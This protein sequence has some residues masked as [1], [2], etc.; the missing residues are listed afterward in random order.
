M[1][2]LLTMS[3]REIKRLKILEQVN[4]DKLSIKEAITSLSVCERQFYR[5][6]KRYREEG[7]KGLVHKSRGKPSN[8]GYPLELKEKVINLYRKTYKDFGPTLFTEKLEELHKIEID[9]ET[10]RRWLRSK[11]EI[12]STRR[13]RGHRKKRERKKSIGEMLQFDGS[14]HDW[15]EGRAPVCCLLHA[16][17]DASSRVFLRF[18]KSENTEEV[19]KTMREY[20]IENGIPHSIYTDRYGVYYAEKEKTDFQKAMSKLGVRCIYANSPQAKGRVERGNRTLQ[21]RLVKEMRLRGISSIDEANKFLRESFIADYNKKF[22]IQ[23]TIP[24][25]HIELNGQNL[26]NIFCY[27]TKRQ[28]RNDY[29]ITLNGH[30]IQLE[31]SE[32]TLPLPKQNVVLRR[33]LDG[34]LHIFYQD[35]ELQYKE[36][37]EKPKAKIK[38]TRKAPKNHIWR[39]IKFGKAKYIKPDR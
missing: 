23:E 32:I 19:L 13:S 24:D 16:I 27:E 34:S 26:D 33:Y 38:V 30:Y 3:I 21:D 6:L 18:A 15:F 28:V 22:S 8:R 37:T 35:D 5:I 9:H 12:T 17:D 2:Q 1:E 4:Q 7:P 25:I 20:V 29:T 10:I 36:L 39:K 11:G 31:K 14:P